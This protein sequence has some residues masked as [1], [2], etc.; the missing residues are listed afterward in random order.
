[1]TINSWNHN[2]S[3]L[4]F[5]KKNFNTPFAPSYPIGNLAA[6]FLTITALPGPHITN[7]ILNTATNN[8]STVWSVLCFFS[9]STLYHQLKAFLTAFVILSKILLI[10]SGSFSSLI[11]LISFFILLIS[12][13]DSI[14]IEYS[15]NFGNA[16][17]WGEQNNNYHDQQHSK[18]P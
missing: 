11:F 13:S 2:G 15:D 9:G 8:F 3:Y 12:V 7:I 16:S 4:S 5:R 18:L 17:F 10:F 1:M 6:T 14:N